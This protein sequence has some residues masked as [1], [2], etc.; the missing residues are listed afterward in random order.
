MNSHL[1]IR[2][3]SSFLI[4]SHLSLMGFIYFQHWDAFGANK[5]C[6]PSPH[7]PRASLR[8]RASW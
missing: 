8:G 7:A 4:I 6:N 1:G 3:V 2:V 5:N